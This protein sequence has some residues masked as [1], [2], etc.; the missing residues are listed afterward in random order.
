MKPIVIRVLLAASILMLSLSAVWAADNFTVY[1]TPPTVSATTSS[2]STTFTLTSA[3]NAP[4][5][6]VCNQGTL[7]AYWQCGNSSVQACVPGAG[8][9]S[10][11]IGA[12]LCGVYHKG[13]GSTTCSAITATGTAT[14]LFTAGEGS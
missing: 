12:G 13:S 1:E 14:V 6:K 4:D 2:S 5:V 10:T 8:C 9:G 7:I 3:I 11:Q